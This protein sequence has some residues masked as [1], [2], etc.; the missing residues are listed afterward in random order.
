MCELLHLTKGRTSRL[1]KNI[2]LQ[3]FCYR[4]AEVIGDV[5]DKRRALGSGNWEKDTVKAYETLKIGDYKINQMRF[6]IQ[7]FMLSF[8]KFGLQFNDDAMNE[9]YKALL[10]RCGKTP[11]EMR[12]MMGEGENQDAEMRLAPPAAGDLAQ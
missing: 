4:Y 7:K 11:E 5:V 9:R 8:N 10:L 6:M 1:M 12:K 2:L 3:S